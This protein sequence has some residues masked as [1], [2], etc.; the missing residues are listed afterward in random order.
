MGR[1][2]CIHLIGA[3][4]NRDH[5]NLSSRLAATLSERSLRVAAKPSRAVLED[6]AAWCEQFSPTVGFDDSPEPDCVLLD[7]TGVTNLFGGEPALVTR[8]R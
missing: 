1:V 6:L 7:V 2:L 4:P 3:L 8:I 5:T